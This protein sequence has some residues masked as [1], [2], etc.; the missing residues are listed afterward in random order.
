MNDELKANANKRKTTR[1]DT[2][3][4]RAKLYYMFEYYL[5]ILLFLFFFSSLFLVR[6]FFFFFIRYVQIR[7]RY[8]QEMVNQL[9]DI[10]ICFSFVKINCWFGFIIE[11]KIICRL[12]RVVIKK[13]KN[14]KDHKCFLNANF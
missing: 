14:L 3:I 8:A 12:I 4:Y 5:N 13:A 11:V 9:S 2:N 1:K 10:C 6:L 7:V